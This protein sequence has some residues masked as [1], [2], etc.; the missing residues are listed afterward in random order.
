MIWRRKLLTPATFVIIIMKIF[1]GHTLRCYPAE[2]QIGNECCP[3][4][5]AGSRVKT[6][7]SEFRST[8]CLSCLHGTFMDKPTGLKECFPCTNC[9]EVHYPAERCHS[10]QEILFPSKDVHGLQQCLDLGL[11]VKTSCTTTSD[12]VCEPLEGFYCIDPIGNNCAA[13]RKHRICH[14]GQYIKQTGTAF[15]DTVCSDCSTGTFSD[16]TFTSCQPHFQCESINLQLIKP[17]NASTDAECGRKS[18]NVSAAV[19][20]PSVLPFLLICGGIVFFFLFRKK[21]MCFRQGEDDRE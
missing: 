8:S 1:P 12:T 18:S 5:P 10:H 2:Y 15:T 9:D 21:E 17:G 13:A 4:C 7:C 14:P 3:M 20:I 6:D 11:K 16:G 19:S